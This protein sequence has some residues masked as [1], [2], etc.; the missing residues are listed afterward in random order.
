MVVALSIVLGEFANVES[1]LRLSLI[2]KE[3]NEVFKESEVV[4]Y[5]KEL[6]DSGQNYKG[7]NG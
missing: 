7:R 4:R 6:D 3:N 2:R 5:D 1:N